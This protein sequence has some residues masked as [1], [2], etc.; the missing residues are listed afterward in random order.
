ML[1]DSNALTGMI[2]E[3]LKSNNNIFKNLFMFLNNYI[4]A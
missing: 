4:F 2:G 1:I 3:I